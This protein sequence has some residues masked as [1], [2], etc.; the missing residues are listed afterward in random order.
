MK[1]SWYIVTEQHGKY[2]ST[3]TRRVQNTENLIK[4]FSGKNII[5][6]YVA[7]TRKEAETE[8]KRVNDIHKKNG[9]YYWEAI[10]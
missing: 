7:S 3:Y 10:A 2:L 1:T 6:V 8:A 4:V 5:S 9:V